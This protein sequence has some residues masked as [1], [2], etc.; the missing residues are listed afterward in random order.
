MRVAVGTDLVSIKR[1]ER[2]TS[3]KH[4]QLIS[5]FS[6]DEI[7]YCL[8]RSYPAASF[9]TRF[10][11]KEAFLKALCTLEERPFALRKVMQ[12]VSINGMIPQLQINWSLLAVEPC[13]N[14]VSLTHTKEIA[15]AIVILTR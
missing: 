13:V 9:A 1:F 7:E 8:A 6:A 5:I 15:Q 3:Y 4:S 10:A 2:W 14:S 12:A 11:A